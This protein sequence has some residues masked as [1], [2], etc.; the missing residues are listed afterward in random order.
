[1][2][3]FLVMNP[4]SHSGRSSRRFDRLE[5]L[6]LKAGIPYDSEM[7]ASMDDA[8]ALSRMANEKG[9]DAIVAVG[10]DGTIN[11]VING[12]YDEEGNRISRAR[13]GVIYTGTSPDFCRSYGIPLRH[14]EAVA[15]LM[16]PETIQIPVGRIRL[17]L[18]QSAG[19][20]GEGTKEMVRYFGC[21]A[22]IGLGAELARRAN[23]GI[24]KYLGDFSGTLLSLLIT[25]VRYRPGTVSFSI[26]GKERTV[27]RMV[28]MSVGLTPYIASGIRMANSN[29]GKAGMFYL[30]TVKDL[31]AARVIPLLRK[32]Y[33]GRPFA[34]TPYLEV[35]WC[36]ELAMDAPQVIQEVEFDGDPAGFLPCRITLATD[37]LDLIR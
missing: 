4:G 9:Y 12:F 10:G 23:G 32:V 7:T 31:H 18:R 37:H 16:D 20:A 21:C 36:R 30:M 29:A 25:L 13:F 3:Y 27:R 28:N 11:G 35:T 22:N 2:N 1:M 24:R 8:R 34:N 6:L 26:D 14:E 19:E 15:R 5:Q 17:Q 33:S